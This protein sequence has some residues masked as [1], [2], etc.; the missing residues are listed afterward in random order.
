MRART[1]GHDI[2]TL[3]NALS[4]GAPCFRI[5]AQ[6]AP[7]SSKRQ[8]LIPC[9][10]CSRCREDDG[11]DHAIETEGLTEDENKNHADEDLLLLSVG[12]NTSVTDDTNGETGSEGRETTSETRGEVL[13]SIAISVFVVFGIDYKIDV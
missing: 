9:G 1:K 3:T 2:I 8:E 10:A 4:D 6:S 11:N 12:S 7:A 13:V 5:V